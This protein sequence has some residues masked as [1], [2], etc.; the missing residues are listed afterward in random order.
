M[1]RVVVT[2]MGTLASNGNSLKESWENTLLGRSGIDVLK[3][4]DTSNLDVKFGG[5]VKGLDLSSHFSSKELKTFSRFTLLSILAAKEALAQAHL[6]PEEYLESKLGCFIGVG[7]GDVG[8]IGQTGKLIADRGPRRVSPFFIP[9]VISNMAAGNTALFFR[10]RGPNI[11]VST[12][13]SSGTHAI[14]EAFLHIKSGSADAIVCGGSEAALCDLTLAGFSRMNAL[15]KRN[16][17]P[18]TAS[19]PFD[20]TRDGFVIAEGAGLL[21]LEELEYAKK[22]GAPILAELVGYGAS[23]DAYH[24]TSPSPQGEGASRCMKAALDS[25]GL[26]PQDIE[27]INAHGSSTYYNDLY[28][29]AAIKSV[30]KEEAKRLL[31]SSTKGATGHSLGGTGGIEACFSVQALREGLIPPT[32]NLE[33][34]GEGLDL[35]YVPQW[36]V[37][38]KISYAMSNSF[39]FGGTNA[40]L[41]FKNWDG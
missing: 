6:E 33:E 4:F 28:E 8:T 22:R 10:L 5:E 1:K 23:C 15:S 38:K 7:I 35:N 31:I 14:G 39:G 16:D 32:A 3:S 20:R 2:G 24:M 12:A 9:Y 41:V 17:S 18:K 40:C 36:A 27:Y 30:F 37:E 25:A 11:S 34:P 29:T 26:A 13:C 21:V 19:R